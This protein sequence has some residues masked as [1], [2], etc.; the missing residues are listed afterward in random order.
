MGCI[1]PQRDRFAQAKQRRCV[2][3]A[4]RRVLA[5]RLGLVCREFRSCCG[6][7]EQRALDEGFGEGLLQQAL[8]NSDLAII[9]HICLLASRGSCSV[10]SAVSAR[11]M[12]RVC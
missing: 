10:V 2:L 9:C 8:Q 7:A 3:V 4:D 5:P 12:C 1:L 6:K 11:P